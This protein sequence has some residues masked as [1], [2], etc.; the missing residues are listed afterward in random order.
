MGKSDNKSDV[1][2]D[3]PLAWLNAD[4]SANKKASDKKLNPKKKKAQ[5]TSPNK[6]GAKKSVT[7][8]AAPK[9]AAPK[10]A[11]PKKVV[12]KKTTAKVVKSKKTEAVKATAND[13]AVNQ[14][15]LDSSLVINKASEV[16]ESLKKLELTGKEVKIDASKVEVI[17]SA[18]LQLLFSFV[19]SL[20]E[21]NIK[22]SW[23]KPTE[24]LLNKASVL[25]LTEQL[26]L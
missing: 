23:H 4:S 17:D 8:K 9:K 1:L 7:K 24:G 2:G 14:F 12:S 11:S 6:A 16:Y 10:R 22:L 26:G 18:I 21:K 25:G 15:V 20:K 13:E 5:K 19:L 3:D